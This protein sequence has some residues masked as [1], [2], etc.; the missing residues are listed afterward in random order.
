MAMQETHTTTVD[1]LFAASQVMP[2]VAD[3]LQVKAS[4]GALKRGALLDKDGTLCNVNDG[5]TTISEVYAVLAEDVDTVSG[6]VTAAVYLTG[7]FNE[8][9]L[10]FK[11]DNSAAIADFKP[12]ARK[13]C[14]FFKPSI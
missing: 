7:E 4:Q 3:K 8:D 9:A 13:V 5:K 14:I 11:T 6:A 12:S 1:N 10:T 2:V